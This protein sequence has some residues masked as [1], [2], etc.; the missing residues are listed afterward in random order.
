MADNK[1]TLGTLEDT[2]DLYFGQKA[3][4]LP[5]NVKELLVRFAPWITLVLLILTL[6][7][8]L[9]ALGLGALAAPLAF[10]AGPA[11][12]FSYGINYTI[13]MM[14]IAVSLI[15]DAL[16]IPGLFKRSA[17]GWRFAYYATILNVLG[18]VIS[19][20]IGGAIL[21]ALIGF[22]LLFQIKSYY[23]PGRSEVAQSA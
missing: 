9:I 11:Y 20:Q 18:S 14:I 17:Q 15:F 23:G 5:T 12:G 21:T 6:P 13:S 8:V 3:P 1:S 7:L 2:L 22:Y 19:F 16:S 10:L 4:A